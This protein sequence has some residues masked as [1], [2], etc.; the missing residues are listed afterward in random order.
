MDHEVGLLARLKVFADPGDVEPLRAVQP[1]RLRGG[2]L[3]KLEREHPHADEVRT[4]N[5]LIAGGDHR[6]DPEQA[7]PLRGPVAAG[8][9]AVLLPR[10]DDE[11]HALGLVFHCGIVDGELL[12]VGEVPGDTAFHARDHQ[13]FDADIGEGTAR[14]H[15]VVATAAAVGVEIDRIDPARDEVFPG[16]GTRLDRPG[17]GNVVGRDGIAENAERA[18]AGDRHDGPGLHPEPIEERR[19]LDVVALRVPLVYAARAGGDLVPLRVLPGEVG[20]ELAEDFRREGGGHRFANFLQARP[21]FAEVDRR[22]VGACPERFVRHV[23][24]DPARERERDNERR[25][26]E[27]VRADALVHARF[28][29]PVPGEHRRGD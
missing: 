25:R 19:L 28:E 4:V 24:V 12:A 14:H 17:G 2:P 18:R 15:A 16:G 22:A 10:E 5:A 7:R 11:R 8:A 1:E 9:G 3:L 23:D 29:I 27:E 20:V 6:L 21:E 26:H 13:V